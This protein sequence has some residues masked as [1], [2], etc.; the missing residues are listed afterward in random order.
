[1]NEA[2]KSA[3]TTWKQCRDLLVHVQP[4]LA[5]SGE[6]RNT[7]LYRDIQGHTQNLHAEMANLSQCVT[8]AVAAMDTDYPETDDLENW[9]DNALLAAQDA[10]NV[11][12]DLARCVRSGVENHGLTGPWA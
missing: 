12:D 3:A 10:F 7:S 4:I 8:L 2:L 6:F 11:A 1:M 5:K 9:T